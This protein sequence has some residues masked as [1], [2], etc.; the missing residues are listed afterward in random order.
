MTPHQRLVAHLAEGALDSEDRAHAS[1]CRACAVL[2]SEGA[3]DVLPPSVEAAWLSAAHREL[4]QPTRPW[5]L[6]AL[7]LGVANGLLALGAVF[8]LQPWNGRE[9]ASGRGLLLATTLVLAALA[10]AGAVLA[11]APRRRWLWGLWAVA[12][13]APVAVLASAGGRAATHPFFAGVHCVWTAVSV[14]VLPL[15]GGAWLLTRVAY[16]PLRALAVGLVSAGVGLLVLQ[17]HCDG[18]RLHVLV[19]HL[20]PWCAI[21]AGAVLL[22]RALPT[23]SFAP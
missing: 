12:A 4:S 8:V 17:L 2:L 13:V 3:E 9:S 19:F 14:S 1:R 23:R 21:G 15:A 18:S 10:S 6:W 11:L 7:W 16:S 22:R 5:W 20:L